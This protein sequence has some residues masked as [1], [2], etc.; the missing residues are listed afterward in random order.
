MSALRD[1]YRRMNALSRNGRLYLLSTL[2]S[3][4]GL[5]IY[6]LFFNLYVLSLGYSEALVGILVALPALVVAAAALPSGYVGDRVGHRRTM[7]LGGL[8]IA[9]SLLGIL[10]FTSVAALIFFT[11]LYGLGSALSSI[12]GAPFMIENSAEEERT[13]L[14][15]VQFALIMIASLFGSL[16]GG[17]LAGLLHWAWGIALGSPRAYQGTLVAAT[18]LAALA[19]WPLWQLAPPPAERHPAAVRLRM[20]SSLGRLVRLLL[21]NALIALGAGLLIPFL[22]VF[23]RVTFHITDLLLGLLFAGGG[24][25][26]AIAALTVPILA[27]RLG[28][29]H[30]IVSTQLTSLPFLLLIGFSGH[31]GWS[32]LGYLM[33]G[34]LMPM[35]SP[36]Y[37]LFVMEHVAGEERAT[38]NGISAM[39]WNVIW[40]AGSWTSGY[41][42]IAWGFNPLFLATTAI[43][44]VG[45]LLTQLYFSAIERQ[46]CVLATV[47]ATEPTLTAGTT[48][49]FKE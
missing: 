1:Y 15:S 18:A 30:T 37:S 46:E 26:T 31:L 36:L 45:T 34:V 35:A 16:L 5:S 10:L 6:G 29:V 14:F 4:L 48:A 7:L 2:V 13:Y 23:F 25:A 47:K 49:T 43:Y 44:L 12:V 32:A 42:Q 9:L 3:S 27:Q 39:S 38:V 33:R 40:A 19:L 20:R 17:A 41:V 28:R 8:L 11:V 22:N 21:P 24:L